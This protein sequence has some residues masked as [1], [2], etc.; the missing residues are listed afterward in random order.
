MIDDVAALPGVAGVAPLH[1]ES[2]TLGNDTGSVLAVTP[3][4]LAQLATTASGSF[5]REALAEAI[6]IDIPGPQVPAGTSGIRLTAAL[7]GFA[8]TPAVAVHIADAHGVLRVLQLDDTPGSEAEAGLT[9]YEGEVPDALGERPRALAAHGGRRPRVR[10][11]GHGRRLRDV[12][13]A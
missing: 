9:A 8:E 10:R 4:V 6:A 7:E 1:V 11:G 3:T 5:D 12:R 2:L 13:D